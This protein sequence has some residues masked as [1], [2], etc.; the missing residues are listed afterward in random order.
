MSHRY[1]PCRDGRSL[2]QALQQQE[3]HPQRD[4]GTLTKP[5]PTTMASATS[6]AVPYI[7]I[8]PTDDSSIPASLLQPSERTASP[9]PSTSTGTSPI[10]AAVAN[11]EAP[12]GP[13]SCVLCTQIFNTFQEM[14]THCLNEHSRSPCLF[15]SKTFAQKANRDRHLC[16]H[17]GD[18]PYSCPDCDEKFSVE[19]S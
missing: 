5:T 13:S 6:A 15:C 1:Q 9:V 2:S 10:K 18:K 17:T 16:L 19:T 7:E 12:P 4:L 14:E 11:I 8:K 3:Q